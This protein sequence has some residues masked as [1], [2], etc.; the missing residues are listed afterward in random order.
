MVKVKG[1]WKRAQELERSKLL[2]LSD[3][4]SNK[5]NYQVAIANVAVA[6][7]SGAQAKANT[8]QAQEAVEKAQRDLG[9][10]TK[11]CLRNVGLKVVGVLSRK[12]AN[13]MGW[14]QDD[15][16]LAP[17]TTIKFRVTGLRQATQTA[18]ASSTPG[19]VNTLSQLYP[20]Q[21]VQLYPPQSAVQALNTPQLTRFSDLDDIWVACGSPK[22]IPVAIRQVTAV[23][24]ERHRIRPDAPDDFKIRDLTKISQTFA[25]TSRV[26]THLL[27]VV[28]LLWLVVGGVGIMNIMLVSVT[29]RTREIGIRMAVGARHPEAIPRRS[30]GPL[31]GWRRRRDIVGPWSVGGHHRAMALAHSAVVAR[32]HCLGRSGGDGRNNFRLLSGREGFT[33][34]TNCSVTVWV[35]TL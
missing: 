23:L 35:N 34:R 15:F 3:Y 17:L 25:A 11:L 29:E 12:G 10:C 24:R 9:F 31:P 18:A 33:P 32:H 16:L 14:D 22:N 13:V 2:S 7:A 5:A 4:E 1:D 28:A 8:V 30:G 21:Q 19:A 20:N 26:M 6:E 27:L